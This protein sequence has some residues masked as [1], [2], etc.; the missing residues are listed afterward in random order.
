M[1]LCLVLC[2]PPLSKLISEFIAQDTTM[3]GYPLKSHAALLADLMEFD[4]HFVQL[5]TRQGFQDR[6]G[7]F[8]IHNLSVTL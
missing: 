8:E 2:S 7:V 4:F 6:Q 5:V 1:V 3:R